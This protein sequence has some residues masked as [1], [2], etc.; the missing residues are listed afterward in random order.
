MNLYRQR[1]FN[2]HRHSD[3]D[4]THGCF[5]VSELVKRFKVK[6]MAEIGVS[7]GNTATEVLA[8]NR[9]KKYYMV[10]VWKNEKIYKAIKDNF[11]DKCVEIIR[12]DSISALK[13]I[14]DESLDLV[15]E[16]AGHTYE[17][18]VEDTH[19]WIKKL[20]HGG[21]LVGDGY[22][23]PRHP[24][25]GVKQAVHEIFKKEEVNVN[26]GLDSIYWVVKP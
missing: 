2:S 13:L 7:I 12:T 24:N 11:Q 9:L 17:R 26:L 10:D 22:C 20:K 15:Y 5:G 1:I 25:Y 19:G 4:K 23:H 21:V 18:T 6:V 3:W 14:E 8:N 16:D